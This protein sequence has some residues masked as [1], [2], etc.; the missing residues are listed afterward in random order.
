MRSEAAPEGVEDVQ[1]GLLAHVRGDV[2]EA[3]TSHPINDS[4]R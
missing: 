1:L 3:E 2:P 4:L